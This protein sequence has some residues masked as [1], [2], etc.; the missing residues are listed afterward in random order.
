MSAMIFITNKYTNWY[1]N[2][3]TNAQA[4]TL[5]KEIYIERHHIIPKSLGGDNSINN[6]VKL[7][8]REHFICHWLLYKMVSNTN[9]SKMANAWFRMCQKNKFQKRYTSRNFELARTAFS[10]NNPFKSNKVI[11]LVKERMTNN[12]PMKN[13]EVAIKVSTKNKGKRVGKNNTF[14]GRKHSIK[15]IV[16]M[17][18]THT[19]K[20]MSKEAI[21]NRLDTIAKN[22]KSRILKLMICPHCGLSGKGGNMSRYHFNNCVKH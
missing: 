5:P 15:S 9:K 22:N 3:I 19:G 7:T 6:L 20:T 17:S 10:K 18:K 8:A 4:R 21:Q 11:N 13:P 2:I 14:Y 12:N 1:Y 16:Q